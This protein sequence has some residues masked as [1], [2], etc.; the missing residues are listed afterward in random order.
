MKKSKASG[1]SSTTSE[2]AALQRAAK[3]TEADAALKRS[4]DV[5]AS[6]PSVDRF[7]AHVLAE[8]GGR[9]AAQW[10]VFWLVEGEQAPAVASRLCWSAG[11]VSESSVE[12]LLGSEASAALMRA[13]ERFQDLR[14]PQLLPV[15]QCA[16]LTE[17]E[18]QALQGVG[19]RSILHLPLILGQCVLGAVSVLFGSDVSIDSE[20]LNLVQAFAHQ[21]TLAI[22]LAQL[23]T[24]AQ[25]AAV[26]QERGRMSREI[27]DTIIQTF[28]A[29]IRNLQGYD[30]R[31]VDVEAALSLAKRGL[32][33][34]RRSVA[35]MRPSLLEGKPF[36]DA[37]HDLASTLSSEGLRVIVSSS[38]VP[39]TLM[40][41]SEGNLFRIV[42]EAVNNVI[43]H[44]GA[45]ELS[46]DVSFLA[47]EV[48]VLVS[49]NGKG[50]DPAGA[51]S[52]HGFGLFSMRQ[53]AQAIGAELQIVSA[54]GQGTQVYVSWRPSA[55][56]G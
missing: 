28:I 52:E 20:D 21:A 40:P 43:N 56:T 35:A 25:N 2:V 22:R 34:A 27:H 30:D 26:V 46:I 41:E 1:G 42:Q 36:V 44:A 55:S 48:T 47:G 19:V 29:I 37:L 16:Y 8:I 54:S 14:F 15:D 18:R 38:G 17:H 31:P 5:L 49:D 3:L 24:E 11:R 7:L 12:D 45:T 4:L 13:A 32:A 50:F 9:L 23:S 53:R 6:Q 39:M 51:D 10:I 33:E